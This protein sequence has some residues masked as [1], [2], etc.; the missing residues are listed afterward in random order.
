LKVKST[1][2]LG[3]VIDSPL[4]CDVHIERT[5]SKI[6]H[7]LFIINKLSNTFD[8]HERKM[9]YYG[10][11]YPLLSHGI[12]AWGQSDKAF[13]RIILILQKRA[14]SYTARLKHI[15]I[16][17]QKTILYVK[18]KCNCI[19]NKSI[20]TYNTRNNNDYHKYVHNLEIRK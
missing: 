20:H 12:V 3:V 11:I 6:S 18:E 13:T 7:N 9:L 4:S 2:F 8:L 17:I 19:V 10:S 5:C 14:V 16:Y 15:Y 1:N